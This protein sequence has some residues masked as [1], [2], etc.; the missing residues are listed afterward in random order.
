MLLWFKWLRWWKIIQAITLYGRE[1]KLLHSSLWKRIQIITL[2]SLYNSPFSS[3]TRY[4]D[5]IDYDYGREFKL[6][7]LWTRKSITW[8]RACLSI[9]IIVLVDLEKQVVHIVSSETQCS[10]QYTSSWLIA[11]AVPFDSSRVL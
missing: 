4:F 6:L 7:H 3:I 5:P 10:F 2:M 9:G 8:K 1:F 11:F